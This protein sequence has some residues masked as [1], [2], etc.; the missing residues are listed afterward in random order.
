MTPRIRSGLSSEPELLESY[1]FSEVFRLRLEDLVLAIGEKEKASPSLAFNGPR[2]D[3][4][5]RRK[6]IDREASSRRSFGRAW[7][8][9]RGWIRS[10][11]ISS[12]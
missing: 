11:L 7:L 10:A 5:F 12:M 6:V 4:V 2:I 1:S 9:W 3:S 8:V